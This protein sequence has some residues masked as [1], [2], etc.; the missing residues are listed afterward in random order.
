[1]KK[2]LFS[3]LLVSVAMLAACNQNNSTPT[4]TYDYSYFNGIC[5]LSGEFNNGVDYALT[6]EWSKSK[7]QALNAKSVRIWIALSGLFDVE[8]NDELIV[9][10][11]YYLTMKDHIDKLKEGGIENFLM[12]YTSYLYPYGY[13]PSTGYVVPDPREEYEQ[14]VS[15]LN[16]QALASKKVKELFPEIRNFEPGNEPDFACPGCIHKNGFIYNGDISVNY[17]YIYNDDDKT[18]I[19]L[20]LCWYVRRAIREV[21][22]NARV[23]FP[24]LTNQ[25]SVPDF[26]DLIYKKI[27]SKTLPVATEKSDTNPDNYFDILNWHP[28]P[29]K[30]DED[31]S[32]KW[33]EWVSYNNSIYQIVKNHGDEGK[34]VY[35]SEIGWTDF[36]VRD[37]KTLNTIADNYTTAYRLIRE[38]MP[39]VTGFFAFRLTNLVH[40]VLDST[41]GEENF[42][43]FY[44]PD[45][46]LTPAKPK[47]AA[48]ALA[49]AFNGEDYDLD[50]HL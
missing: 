14:Y 31:N 50:A 26:V 23:V 17:D 42:G 45:D 33:D 37:E 41:G 12:L 18:A 47:P 11:K 30:F 7:V 49:K 2:K 24:G 38:N 46:P 43:L 19:L 27:E 29:N 21:D 40:Q 5:A 8:E 13:I 36:G 4:Y 9:N 1:M 39:Y 28:Y 10:Q 25:A 48:Y 3:L 16:L 15:F 22:E 44:H 32:I 6:N 20:D 34:E 35:F